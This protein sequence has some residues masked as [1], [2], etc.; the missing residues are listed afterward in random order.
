MTRYRLFDFAFQSDVEFP[1]LLPVTEPATFDVRR[2]PDPRR[3]ARVRWF[4]AF[5]R[6]DGERPWLKVGRA[7]DALVMRFAG[8]VSLRCD[9]R[10]IFWSRETGTGDASFRH[11]VLDQALPLIAAHAGRIVLHAASVATSRGAL[12]LAGPTGVGKSTLVAAL[13]SRCGGII[14]DD[15]T[16][17]ALDNGV[18]TAHAAYATVRLWPDAC[19]ALG[20]PQGIPAWDGSEKQGF[21]DATRRG[22]SAG[23]LA[24]YILESAPPA[25]QPAVRDLPARDAVVALVRNSFV[26][27]PADRARLSAQFDAL[28]A[29]APRVPVRALIVPQRFEALASVAGLLE[30]A[31][32]EVGP[33]PSAVPLRVTR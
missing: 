2:D 15:A 22:A 8:G 12:L 29:I 26:L 3:A 28:S 25:V 10:N 13:A 1:E 21:S 33:P 30:R 23:V 11:M 17:V 24:I 6:P 19:E 16:T 27:D 5:K 32:V 18:V 7:A 31:L 9:G 4:H 14:G 20:Y